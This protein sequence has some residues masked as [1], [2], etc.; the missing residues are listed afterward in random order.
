MG[1]L[2]LPTGRSGTTYINF[3]GHSYLNTTIGVYDQAYRID[4][5]VRA[6]YGISPNATTNRALSG[7]KLCAENPGNAG[8]ATTLQQDFKPLR[9]APYVSRA[10]MAV[11]CW[12]INDPGML[13]P[14]SDPGTVMTQI[15]AQFKHALRAVISRHRS[16]TVFEAGGAE[17]AAAWTAFGAGF[18]SQASVN[19]NS[20]TAYRRATATTNATATFTI[21]A[22]FPGGNIAMG[23]VGA[24]GVFGGTVTVGGTFSGAKPT[25]STSNM[26]PVG[27]AGGHGH[28]CQR[29]ANLPSS[30]AT[31][32]ITLTVAT[33]DASGE[34]GVDY[35]QIEADP[36]PLV[37][38][39]NIARL[40]NNAAYASYGNYWG[41][42]GTPGSTGDGDVANFNADIASVVAEFDGAV[43][44]A[45]IDTALG[46]N[47]AYFGVDGIH[48]NEHGTRKCAQAIKT[49]IDAAPV[50]VDNLYQDYRATLGVRVP[51]S[52]QCWY[53]P[54]VNMATATALTSPMVLGDTY[55]IPWPVTEA[56]ERY[57]G[58]AIHVT[59]AFTGTALLR[60]GLYDDEDWLGYPQCVIDDFGT[61]WSSA[62]TGT[63]VK[64]ILTPTVNR[65][66]DPGM[67]WLVLKEEGTIAA[68][69]VAGYT[70]NSPYVPISRTAAAPAALNALGGTGYKLTGQ[71]AGSLLTGLQYFPRGAALVSGTTPS[72]MIA[73][74]R[75]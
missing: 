19:F 45:D 59:T 48:P 27:G 15:R 21:P 16:A 32:T 10:G 42:T 7:A 18:A 60:V 39:C 22:D 55:A 20:G 46:K 2:T 71:P 34:I 37:V 69:A 70:G 12:G 74:R 62:L 58:V 31:K 63:G 33:V 43:V 61:T 5:L 28:Y 56:A 44:V 23:F 29:W 38:V 68:G 6:M 36:P 35:A 40:V 65:A 47:A 72:P 67:Y 13:V 14:A 25:I 53:G 41:G 4:Y 51:R 75:L 49:A 8:W 11:Y 52:S 3:A 24:A 30:D 1:S 73:L 26:M 54:E 57:D 9:G 17:Q 50:G 66:L 64:A